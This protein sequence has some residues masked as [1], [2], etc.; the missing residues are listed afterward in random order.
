MTL[1]KG[2][3]RR[4]FCSHAFDEKGKLA[5]DMFS[6][7]NCVVA[8]GEEI[9]TCTCHDEPMRKPRFK[10][11]EERQWERKSKA[12][13]FVGNVAIWTDE[14]RRKAKCHLCMEQIEQGERRIAFDSNTQRSHM[15]MSGGVIKSIRQYVHFSC[16]MD[17]LMDGHVGDGCPGCSAKAVNDEWQAVR[18]QILARRA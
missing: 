7:M 5:R 2:G 1:H 13:M 14:A 15:A 12:K 17:V 9:P 18:E 11:V 8:E 6:A 16:F 4:Y 3:A 10:R